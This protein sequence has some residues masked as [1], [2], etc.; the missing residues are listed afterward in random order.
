MTEEN[1]NEAGYNQFLQLFGI[2][3]PDPLREQRIDA[4]RHETREFLM[5]LKPDQLI[6][7]I[8]II[9]VTSGSPQA[10]ERFLGMISIILDLKHKLCVACGKDHDKMLEEMAE[11]PAEP[12]GAPG[13]AEAE[14]DIFD[15]TAKNLEVYEME[16]NEDGD[17]VCKNCGTKYPSMEDRMLR[18]PGKPG[19]DPCIQRE[20]WG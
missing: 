17:L 12:S 20:K 18:R 13:A 10:G 19:C 8:E 5:S 1:P 6:M 11:A 15:Q 14:A 3:P 9:R 2:I 16:Y 4:H 7:L